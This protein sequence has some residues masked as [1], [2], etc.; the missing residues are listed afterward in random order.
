MVDGVE[1]Y[2]R[3]GSLVLT[4]LAT[5]EIACRT[6]EVSMKSGGPSVPARVVFWDGSDGVKL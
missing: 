2:L 6:D 4:E 3:K 1:V 5:D